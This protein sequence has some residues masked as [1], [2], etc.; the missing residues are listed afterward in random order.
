MIIRRAT[1]DDVPE[2]YKLLI[3]MHDGVKIP[4]GEISEGKLLHMIKEIKNT[5]QQMVILA[6]SL[7]ISL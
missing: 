1:A 2:I 4:V 5:K 7:K 3:A 6:D